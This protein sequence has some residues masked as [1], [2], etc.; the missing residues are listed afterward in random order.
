LIN[1]ENCLSFV[2]FPKYNNFSVI[3]YA[4][5]F[6]EETRKDPYKKAINHLFRALPVKILNQVAL[7]PGQDGLKRCIDTSSPRAGAGDAGLVARGEGRLAA[8]GEPAAGAGH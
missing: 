7:N 4:G 1:R 8:Q 3:H 6:L 5:V 2:S